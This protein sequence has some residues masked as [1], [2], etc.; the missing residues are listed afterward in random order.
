MTEESTLYLFKKYITRNFDSSID[1]S[2]IFTLSCYREW[3]SMKKS[4]P[5]K[6]AE[7]FR[8]AITGHVRGD[9]GLHPFTHE[10]ERA[11]LRILRQKQV[12]SCF[13]GTDIKIG[14]RGFQTQGFW[15]RNNKRKR[16]ASIDDQEKIF[17]QGQE[18]VEDLKQE[19]SLKR[20]KKFTSSINIDF[21]NS[22]RSLRSFTNLKHTK[23]VSF[24][25]F[26]KSYSE[27]TDEECSEIL[28]L[29]PVIQSDEDESFLSQ[30]QDSQ[31]VQFPGSENVLSQSLL[32]ILAM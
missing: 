30:S 13:K 7:A 26:Y 27:L 31:I 28:L 18:Q 20:V 29:E 11:V 2:G 10:V 16:E 5:K 22:L 3:L 32:N 24:N 6:P 9:N 4:L 1:P 14:L 19:R 15:E 23:Q 17:C 21:N 8:K 12:W 25:S